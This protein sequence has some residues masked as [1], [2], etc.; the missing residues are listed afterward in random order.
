MA[1]QI[2]LPS[3]GEN[4][5]S[6]DV[7]SILVREG[8]TVKKDQDLLEIETDKATMP[9]PSPQAGRI[10]KVLVSAGQTVKVGAPILEIEAAEAEESP[11]KKKSEPP[12][13]EKAK[14]EP[15]KAKDH[16]ADEPEPE[17][18]EEH[19]KEADVVAGDVEPAEEP[20]PGKSARKAKSR[21]E[22]DEEETEKKSAV[23]TKSKRPKAPPD[24][25][26][27]EDVPGDGRASAAAGPAVRRLARQLGV[28][29]R[30]VR[31]TGSGGRIT[32]EDIR[33]YIRETNEQ[34][35]ATTPR[36]LTPPGAPDTDDFGAVRI[37]KMSRMRQTIARNMIQSYTTIPQLTN[38]DDADVTE[39]EDMREQSKVDYA[40]RG[41]K[42]TALPFV[43]KAVAS[44]LKRHPVVNAS[45]DM[46][47]HQ[48]IYKEYVNIGIAVDTERG[49]VVPVLRDAD[50]KSISQIASEIDE[51]ASTV[52][53]GKFELDILRGGTFA[54]SNLGAIG[55][56]Y[57]TPLI[58][59]GQVA[60]LLIGR[61]RTVPQIVDDA[62]CP[63]LMMPLSI[64]Y[65]HRLVDGA[66]AA[67][68][69]NEVKGFLAAPGRLLL[70]P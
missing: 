17:E 65:D 63:R 7:L 36:G 42:L 4:I 57:S 5:E 6:G 18:V 35:A 32:T 66:A 1:T 46:E 3:L 50:R 51:L 67:R 38:F 19:A 21:P 49:L 40:D 22:P 15:R 11:P 39:L 34:V 69:L 48:I 37:E 45:V 9:V 25:A 56:T 12:Q 2:K 52:R 28:E 61:T 30:R 10:A 43:I 33:A 54:I 60:I 13:E 59:P 70:A 62:I 47:N 24:D 53:D 16:A 27:D 58:N 55:G 23:A 14:T 20:K 41:I 8:D 31:P 29:L 26:T 68:F 64:T 44:A